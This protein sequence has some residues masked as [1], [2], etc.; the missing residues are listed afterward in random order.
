MINTV[1]A[2][3]STGRAMDFTSVDRG[4][5]MVKGS[6]KM[7][8]LITRDGSFMRDSNG[9]LTNSDGMQVLG[10]TG[11]SIRH[12]FTMTNMKRVQD[13]AARNRLDR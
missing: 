4:Y 11:S 9:T 7:A 5:F 8:K 2:P 13:L 10:R 12:S 3:Q 6:A 1:G